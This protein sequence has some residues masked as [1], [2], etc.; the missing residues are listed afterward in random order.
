M[1]INRIYKISGLLIGL[2]LGFASLVLTVPIFFAI[3]GISLL[4]DSHNALTPAWFIILGPLAI[5]GLTAGICHHLGSKIG[6]RLEADAQ[7]EARNNKR[8]TIIL[9]LSAL[10]LLVGIVASVLGISNFYQSLQSVSN[11]GLNSIT[12]EKA[13]EEQYKKYARIGTVSTEFKEPFSERQGINGKLVTVSLYRKLEINVPIIVQYAGNYE[14]SVDYG[15]NNNDDIYSS[16]V[17][18]QTKNQFL[19]IGENLISFDFVADSNTSVS[20]YS[21][22]PNKALKIQLLYLATRDEID[23]QNKQDA[24]K[25]SLEYK[26]LVE[27]AQEQYLK[28]YGQLPSTVLK[29]VETKEILF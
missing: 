20:S 19:N 26:R 10:F 15:A 11:E 23:A 16:Y 4:A 8:G 7:N 29:F 1:K 21:T 13:S 3:F 24:E 6:K 18:Q 25:M 12:A 5:V 17:S 9:L 14:I 2:A 28:D 27:R 22:V